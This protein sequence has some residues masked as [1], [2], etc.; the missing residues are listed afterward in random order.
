MTSRSFAGLVSPPKECP[1][2]IARRNSQFAVNQQQ[3]L[4]LR[5]P[6]AP[7]LV[8]PREGE[9][10]PEV[11]DTNDTKHLPQVRALADKAPHDMA[12]V[13]AALQV[14]PAARSEADIGVLCGYISTLQ[15]GVLF[16]RLNAA[17]LRLLCCQSLNLE[18]FTKGQISAF[19]LQTFEHVPV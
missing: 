1:P 17:D 12:A 9:R 13:I 2:W 19:L 6:G 8:R 3:T 7:D 16:A 14:A 18:A 4:H 15:D 10:I 5:K 11:A